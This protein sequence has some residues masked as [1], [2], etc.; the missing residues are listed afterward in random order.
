MTVY[1]H[2]DFYAR[3]QDESLQL[4]AA[5][6]LGLYRRGNVVTAPEWG[7]A[8][9]PMLNRSP[10]PGRTTY[11]RSEGE[12]STTT[13]ASVKVTCY[14]PHQRVGIELRAEPQP[15][16]DELS[17]ERPFAPFPTGTG[18]SPFDSTSTN[19]APHV[20]AMPSLVTY[21]PVAYIERRFQTPAVRM[22]DYSF[23]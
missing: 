22:S 19:D 20:Q 14:S 10:V 9:V 3:N 16:E 15:D 13:V 2:R 4:S 5:L 1:V 18:F 23:R 11:W 6:D 7:E 21:R 17:W 12:Q 8:V